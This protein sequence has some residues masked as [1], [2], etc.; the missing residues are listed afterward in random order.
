MI[1]MNVAIEIHYISDGRGMQKGSFPLRG[2]K[3]VKIALEFWQQ[4]KKEMSNRAELEKVIVDGD[5]DITQLV[6][7]L[8]KQ[9][10]LEVMYED[11]L[12]F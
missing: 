10:M 5:Q 7:E 2:R 6:L 9:T 8:E 11:N 4:I 12:P 1:Y 3:P